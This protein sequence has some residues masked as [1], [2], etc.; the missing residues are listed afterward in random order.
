[1]ELVTPSRK[2]QLYWNKLARISQPNHLNSALR[3]G[4]SSF[5]RI[6]TPHRVNRDISEVVRLMPLPTTRATIYTGARNVTA[7]WETGKDSQIAT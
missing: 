7:M 6:V 4:G 1:M 2:A 3:I 5:R